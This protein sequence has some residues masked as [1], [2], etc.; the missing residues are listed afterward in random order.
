[1]GGEIKHDTVDQYA[2]QHR[3]VGLVA[4]LMLGASVSMFSVV[5][6]DKSDVDKSVH[7]M[8]WCM[9]TYAFAAAAVITAG[10]DFAYNRC[11]DVQEAYIFTEEMGSLAFDLPVYFTG[12]GFLLFVIGTTH[13]FVM[14]YRLGL[15]GQAVN[16]SFTVC[17][18]FCYAMPPFVVV[19]ILKMLYSLH[20]ASSFTYALQGTRGFTQNDITFLLEKYLAEVC[21]FEYMDAEL[22]GFIRF[23]QSCK[24]KDVSG[25]ERAG[26]IEGLR[27]KYVE[28]LWEEL[29]SAQ[30]SNQGAYAKAA[31]E[32]LADRLKIAKDRAGL[33]AE[34]LADSLKIAKDRAQRAQ[35]AQ[36]VPEP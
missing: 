11:A 7:G 2:A 8:S 1:M 20:T 36:P 34:E 29:Y 5:P 31:A 10:S 6:A 12:L 16:H 26:K 18:A 25:K 24:I 30:V 35:P 17:A 22:E 4:A 28:Q 13:F 21:K 32:E 33:P 27:R 14:E 19:A 3:Q 15:L 23:A 9:A